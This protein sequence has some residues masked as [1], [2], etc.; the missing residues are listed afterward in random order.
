[1]N[2]QKLFDYSQPLVAAATVLMI[3]GI[4]IGV[5][6]AYTAYNIKLANDSLEV[7][8]SAK[9]AVVADTARWIINLDTKTGV[10]DQQQ[11]YTRLEAAATKI[12]AYLEE[13][14][15]NDYET[16][17][18]T[19]YP[20]YTYP[21]YGEP[22][23]TGFNVARQIIVRSSDVAAINRLANNIEP[24]TG[25]NYN[26]TTQ[27]LELTYSKL[28][29]MRVQLLSEAIKDAKARA[30]AIASESGRSVKVLRNAS[31]GVVQVLPAG[32]IEVSDYGTYDTQSMNKEVMVTV[33]AT[34]SL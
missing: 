13:Q 32:S 11:G 10:N 3:G 21:Q 8:G 16:P 1:M 6:G 9:Q 20:N 22:I 25:A 23:F 15:F 27:S 26:V 4:V 2:I 24:F 14:G 17:A 7:T 5:L 12:T 28:D 34:F 29:E 30:E 33:R 31:S 18:V 19:S